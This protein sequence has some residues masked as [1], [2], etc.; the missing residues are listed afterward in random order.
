MQHYPL[1]KGFSY[2]IWYAFDISEQFDLRLIQADTRTGFDLEMYY[3]FARGFILANV[4]AI[5]HI[6]IW[7]GFFLQCYVTGYS[8]TI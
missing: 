2:Q 5:I 6:K 1:I 8:L 3:T 7:S 4:V